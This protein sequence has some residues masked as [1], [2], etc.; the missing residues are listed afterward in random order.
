MDWILSHWEWLLIAFYV[1]EKA[2]HISKAKW[3]DIL[4]DGIKAIALALYELF[5]DRK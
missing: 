2:V 3:D 5:K 1:V 4:V